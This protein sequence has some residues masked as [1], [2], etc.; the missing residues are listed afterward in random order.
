M[1]NLPLLL[2]ILA[3]TLLLAAFNA[4]RQGNEKRD[5]ALLGTLGGLFGLG[6]ALTA[7]G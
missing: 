4:R 3:A 1:D 7:L 5:L 2:A 6:S